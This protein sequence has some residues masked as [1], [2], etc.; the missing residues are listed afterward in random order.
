[1]SASARTVHLPVIHE[2][3]T[4]GSGAGKPYH[5]ILY[6]DDTHAFDAVV[7]QVQKATGVSAEEAFA[8][9]LQA[10]ELGQSACY[11]GS[12]ETCRRVADILREIALQV[13]VDRA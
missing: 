10:H 8:I 3:P 12:H 7:H 9:T 2:T 1:M 13:E 5:V 6:N 4:T 11:A